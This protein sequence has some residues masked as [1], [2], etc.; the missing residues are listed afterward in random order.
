MVAAYVPFLV[1]LGLLYQAW[2]RLGKRVRFLRSCHQR[3]IFYS[4]ACITLEHVAAVSWVLGLVAISPLRIKPV[5][6][7]CESLGIC[8]AFLLMSGALLYLYTLTH[9]PRVFTS[10]PCWSARSL[11]AMFRCC[12][13]ALCKVLLWALRRRLDDGGRLRRGSCTCARRSGLAAFVFFLVY[14]VASCCWMLRGL[15]LPFYVEHSL[16]PLSWCRLAGCWSAGSSIIRGIWAGGGGWLRWARRE[17]IAR[18]SARWNGPDAR[19][20]SVQRSAARAWIFS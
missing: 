5:I 8:F 10:V 19:S 3:L 11:P 7:R 18:V 15:P 9:T 20:V 14:A 16:A 12:W 6:V 4:I 17:F 1:G 13:H 2:F